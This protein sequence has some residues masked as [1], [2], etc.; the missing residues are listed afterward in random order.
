MHA[1]VTVVVATPMI[2]VCSA[3]ILTN[4]T[5]SH[6]DDFKGSERTIPGVL[7]KEKRRADKAR[8]AAEVD[9]SWSTIA[10]KMMKKKAR[11]RRE[12][13]VAG[14][15]MRCCVKVRKMHRSPFK[16]S[17][18]SQTPSRQGSRQDLR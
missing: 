2:S 10:L 17:S 9:G 6:R 16:L 7:R 1:A 11:D 8:R 3:Y 5:Y 14:M 18:L 4:A 13:Q 12:M 15:G